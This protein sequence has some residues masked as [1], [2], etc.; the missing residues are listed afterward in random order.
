MLPQLY[1]QTWKR[2]R[3][4]VCVFCKLHA[5]VWAEL[6]PGWHRAAAAS[7]AWCR[8]VVSGTRE[9]EPP[10]SLF[11]NTQQQQGWI[12]LK[13][14]KVRWELC[15]SH[16]FQSWPL[17]PCWAPL[18]ADLTLKCC[19]CLWSGVSKFVL[20]PELWPRP[21][22][23]LSIPLHAHMLKYAVWRDS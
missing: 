22:L 9:A 14:R 6:H 16:S 17:K 18:R 8:S 21:S 13:T 19:L 2:E 1:S 20:S 10:A 12:P 11:V 4:K 5:N 7:F 15:S 3:K 23:S